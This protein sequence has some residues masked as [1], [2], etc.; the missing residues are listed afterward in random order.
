MSF[1]T[2]LN[3]HFL[4]VLE[5]YDYKNSDDRVKYQNFFSQIDQIV[6]K[7]SIDTLMKDF[8][9]VVSGKMSLNISIKLN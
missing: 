2:D 6:R 4:H 1:N 3:E 7:Q 8:K 5:F 9:L